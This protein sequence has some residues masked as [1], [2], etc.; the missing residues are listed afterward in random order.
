[1]IPNRKEIENFVKT[2][3]GYKQNIIAYRVNKSVPVLILEHGSYSSNFFDRL[4]RFMEAKQIDIFSDKFGIVFHF[5]MPVD[6]F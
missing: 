3:L 4:K 5:I 2:Q 1:M 6:L